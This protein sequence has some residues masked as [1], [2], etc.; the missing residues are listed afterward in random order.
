MH[1]LLFSVLDDRKVSGPT[2]ISDPII[3]ALIRFRVFVY[4]YVMQH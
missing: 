3:G 4:V 2:R 1:K